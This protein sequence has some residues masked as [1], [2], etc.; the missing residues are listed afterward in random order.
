MPTSIKDFITQQTP[1]SGPGRF[2]SAY[3]G[4]F[5]VHDQDLLESYENI[6]K[7]IDDKKPDGD[8]V[9][10]LFELI[11]SSFEAIFTEISR[12]DPN[13][14]I[15]DAQKRDIKYSLVFKLPGSLLLKNIK[16]ASGDQKST[17][18][19]RSRFLNGQSP[20]L[21]N[22]AQKY[23]VKTK[24]DLSN[25]MESFYNAQ[26]KKSYTY[27]ADYIPK[28]KK[29]KIFC[30]EDFIKEI[31]FNDNFNFITL[32]KEVQNKI[33]K[34]LF[35]D[36]GPQFVGIDDMF[37]FNNALI[38]LE[39]KAGNLTDRGYSDEAKIIEA[40]V[41][42]LKDEQNKFVKKDITGTVFCKNCYNHLTSAQ[43]SKLSNHRILMSKPLKILFNILISFATLGI[44][45]VITGRAEVFRTETD[46]ATKINAM[47][48]KLKA[49]REHLPQDDNPLDQGTTRPYR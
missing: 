4:D 41:S 16:M 31:K 21:T 13:W 20:V 14:T 18:L 39:K 34:N 10:K 35:N 42:S 3:E 17:I 47:K 15:T 1:A 28:M 19:K 33:I 49:L 37:K 26:Y 9:R 2:F 22:L 8:D 45:N 30:E 46:S 25:E 6:L 48:S 12:D 43:D 24:T 23:F 40:L 5:I 32:P 27:F 44:A 38:N 36:F 7:N 11:N 29:E